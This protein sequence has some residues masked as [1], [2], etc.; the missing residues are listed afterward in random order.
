MTTITAESTLTK[1]Q[2]A[3][4]GPKHF[5][6]HD[7]PATITANVRYDDECGNGHNSFSITAEIRALD[8]RKYREGQGW[9]AGGCCHEEIA[10]AFSELA[11][12]IKWHLCSSDGPMHYIANT[13]YLASDR[14]CHGKKAG[15]PS[16][17]SHA[18]QF[19]SNPIKHKISKSF[20]TFLQQYR[21]ALGV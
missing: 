19:G 3:K 14:D 20:S 2:R 18:V 5:T 13:I 16:S 4:F 8:R 21:K 6:Y 17:F 11:P 9:M 15:E 1:R 12:L 10:K 7:E